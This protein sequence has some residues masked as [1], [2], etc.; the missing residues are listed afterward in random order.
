MVVR[1]ATDATTLQ[2]GMLYR[3]DSSLSV[4]HG[5]RV[6]N[7]H[8]AST[9]AMDSYIMNDDLEIEYQDKRGGLEE[10]QDVSVGYRV[11]RMQSRLP[12]FVGYIPPT[13]D[14]SYFIFIYVVLGLICVVFVLSCFIKA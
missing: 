6:I 11:P 4:K 5:G 13:V 10:F 3:W 14:P 7:I 12:S 1:L 9:I 8:T 2:R